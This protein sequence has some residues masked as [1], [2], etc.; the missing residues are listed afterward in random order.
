MK[1]KIVHE[2]KSPPADP[3]IELRAKCL[4]LA[5]EVYKAE[6]SPK[7][8]SEILVMAQRYYQFAKTGV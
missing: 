8:S 6:S 5:V 7:R 3:Q 1:L 2:P 4:S